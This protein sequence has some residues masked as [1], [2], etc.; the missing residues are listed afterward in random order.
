MNVWLLLVSLQKPFIMK[1]QYW[2]SQM[3]FIILQAFLASEKL[4]RKSEDWKV[5]G[6]K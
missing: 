1:K 6:E 5:K 3:D 2:E 4:E